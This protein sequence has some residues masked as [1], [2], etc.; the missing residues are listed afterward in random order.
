MTDETLL[1]RLRAE[2]LKMNL[3]RLRDHLA[4]PDR[5]EDLKKL[6]ETKQDVL[7]SIRVTEKGLAALRDMLYD[8]SISRDDKIDPGDLGQDAKTVGLTFEDMRTSL[9][10]ARIGLMTLNSTIEQMTA[11]CFQV[12]KRPVGAEI[13]DGLGNRAKPLI[14]E[15]ENM[16]ALGQSQN[17]SSWG[18][19]REKAS[20]TEPILTD[21][22][23]LLGGAALR[24]T[25]FDERI[26]DIADE[27]LGSS[28]GRLLALPVRQQ[29]LVR[30]IKQIIRVTFP[31]WSIWA[32]PSAA[33]EVWNVVKRE[34][35][36]DTL[37]ANLGNLES[38]DQNLIR[39]EHR[40]CLGDAY[41]TYIMGPAYAYYAVGL[42]LAPDSD[43]DH[44]RV[45]AIL[46]MLERMEE[47]QQVGTRYLAV[48][49]QLLNAWNG[50]RTQLRQSQLNLNLDKP[51]HA[52]NSDP[53]GK[54]V[55]ILIEGLWTTLQSETSA[56]F[57][58]EI[59][60]EIEP[61]VGLLLEDN[62]EQIPVPNGAEMRHLLNAAW[63]ARCDRDRNLKLDLN[64]A[65]KTLLSKV[66]E[67]QQK[68]GR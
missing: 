49:K 51:N 16:Q 28:R 31:D 11:K 5:I 4:V 30:T 64:A 32:L 47:S 66:K 35:V 7:N 20:Q 6:T 39:P 68:K 65:I 61:W 38:D 15:L 67:R 9:D 13:V 2:T 23:E 8:G 19:L 21:Y 63:L 54:G 42:L 60:T 58:A 50:A 52:D 1:L 33:L 44:C 24:D 12:R 53:E 57:G 10:K 45:R 37:R 56:K 48:R 40:Q 17:G 3:A 55:R 41:A 34:E 27:L 25:G 46:T 18:A 59:W 26:S 29:A 22:M 43:V 14:A 36:A 62:A